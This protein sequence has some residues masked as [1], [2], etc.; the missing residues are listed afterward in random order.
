MIVSM[1]TETTGL[2]PYH[3]C[4]P[5][6]VTACDGETNYWWA[7]EVNCFNREVYWDKKD[8]RD[9]QDFINSAR[10][11]IMH[12]AKF[13]IRMLEYQGIDVSGI[14]G[15]LEET[16]IAAH[17]LNSAGA[18]KK[19]N[20]HGLKDLSVKY[21]DQWDDDE[22]ELKNAVRE[23]VKD[24][25][26]NN[27][28]VRKHYYKHYP[29]QRARIEQEYW[30]CMDLCL[31]Y[32]LL[33]A[34][35]TWYLWNT[36]KRGLV[37]D[38][39]WEPYENRRDLVEVAYR[40]EEHGM[41]FYTE[42][43]QEFVLSSTQKLE[44]IRQE[45]K[46]VSGIRYKLDLNRKEHL[47]DLLHNRLKIEP[48]FFTGKTKEPQ[49]TKNALAYYLES[50]YSDPKVAKAI[51]LVKEWKQENKDRTDVDGFIKWTDEH[52]RIHS[53]CWITGTRETRQSFTD[54]ATQTIK[55]K[56]RKY[57]G[58]PPGS[59]CVNFDLV[60]IELRIWAYD[61]GNPKLIEAFE[62][63]KSV[64]IIIA[65]IIAALMAEQCPNQ[66]FRQLYIRLADGD[67]KGYKEDSDGQ[68]TS[69]YTSLKNGN[70]G[71]IYGASDLTTNQAYS[72]TKS[73]N[74]PNC[75]TLIDKEL[76]GVGD[77]ARRQQQAVL[78]N[79]AKYQ[80]CAIHTFG[81]YRLDVP[82][83]ELQKAC[84]YR[85]QGSAGYITTLAML[86]IFRDRM[87]RESNSHMIQQVHDSINIEIPIQPGMQKLINRFQDC[88]ENAG[89][90]LIPTCNASYKIQYNEA[91][92]GNPLI[93]G[94]K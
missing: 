79:I 11:I 87:Y 88:I 76:P 77:Y 1:D 24:A 16:L 89:M 42:K 58:P 34:E 52:S 65:K 35:R 41:Y 92:L 3:G 45:L 47:V 50:E 13:D 33:D 51:E 57:W 91:D 70:F 43:A 39:L 72:G 53:V 66:E 32:G 61:T 63:G 6:L 26:A 67:I 22:E 55:K 9:L 93:E 27:W 48:A 82:Y 86:E 71:R 85:I 4:R 74:P 25:K 10:K 23:A 37:L 54:P 29:A 40:M 18:D 21:L 60:N 30:L 90:R 20:E 78:N 80:V 81:G 28:C 75:C 84:N 12:N 46:Q 15:K 94:L 62:H 7:G 2:D 68:D 36:F 59:I 83:D 17:C 44:Q 8:L 73:K 56:L 5:Y 38:G 69:A 14:F 49:V 64:H 31:K 19:Q